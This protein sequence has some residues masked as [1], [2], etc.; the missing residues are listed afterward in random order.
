M[1]SNDLTFSAPAKSR[2]TLPSG[3]LGMLIFVIAEAMFFLALLCSFGIAK[4]QFINWPP[5]GLPTLPTYT[6]AFNTMVFLS[7][8]FFIYR[9]GRLFE[10]DFK[11]SKKYFILTLLAG[12]F[13]LIFQ[14]C[15]WF[16][17]V[18]C[19]LTLQVDQFGS[20]FN[21]LICTHAL[22]LFGALCGM[23][24]IMTRFSAHTLDASTLWAM[25]ILW[26][27]VV[28]IWPLIYILVYF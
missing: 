4:S 25:Q 26:Y 13:F 8:G 3:V 22:H 6:T 23:L 16:N 27:F 1:A 28:G 11:K 10:N 24:Y 7:S 18:R 5:L 21:T 15:E 14:G 2:R 9:S 19:G 12:L 17:L 20:F